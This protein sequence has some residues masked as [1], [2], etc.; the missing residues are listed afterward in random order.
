MFLNIQI[1]LLILKT[2]DGQFTLTTKKSLHNDVNYQT[3]RMKKI[4][5][6]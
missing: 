4:I 1:D 3:D 6:I 5:K 2:Y